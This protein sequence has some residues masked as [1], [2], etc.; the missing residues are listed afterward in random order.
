MEGSHVARSPAVHR[1][2]TRQR[3][4]IGEQHSGRETP[5]AEEPQERVAGLEGLGAVVYWAR[6]TALVRLLLFTGEGAGIC[7]RAR[8]VAISRKAWAARVT[9]LSL[10][11]TSAI[12][13]LRRTPSSLMI[14]TSPAF[15]SRSTFVRGRNPMPRPAMISR[16]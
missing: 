2:S 13:R 14:C 4:G 1:I 5:Q 15:S 16:L 6:P 12:S 11:K 10:R 9:V 8:P 3:A 7:G